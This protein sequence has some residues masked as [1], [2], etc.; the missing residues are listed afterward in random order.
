MQPNSI[1]TM[2]DL[3]TA[4]LEYLAYERT[5]YY[6]HAWGCAELERMEGT[7]SLLAKE[8]VRAVDA[9]NDRPVGWHDRSL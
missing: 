5:D 9:S 6:Q 3:V 2:F 1:S 8:H 4:V 7:I